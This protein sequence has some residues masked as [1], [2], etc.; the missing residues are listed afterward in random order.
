MTYKEQPR[1]PAGSDKG[2]EWKTSGASGGIPKQWMPKYTPE[3]FKAWSE[4]HPTPDSKWVR[5]PRFNTT[6]QLA[7]M[8][9]KVQRLDVAD[10]LPFDS[11][12]YMGSDAPHMTKHQILDAIDSEIERALAPK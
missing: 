7:A 3:Q 1:H 10:D 8:R 2:G 4:T 11:Q 9:Q 5:G 12:P 6:D